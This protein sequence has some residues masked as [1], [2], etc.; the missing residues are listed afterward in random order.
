MGDLLEKGIEERDLNKKLAWKGKLNGEGDGWSGC[1]RAGVKIKP[2]IREGL[3][4]RR[5][6]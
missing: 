2:C 6:E 4:R 3:I 1:L 5:G